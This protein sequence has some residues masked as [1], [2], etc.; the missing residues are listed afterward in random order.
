MFRGLGRRNPEGGSSY[1]VG[2]DNFVTDPFDG[3][4]GEWDVLRVFRGKYSLHIGKDIYMVRGDGRPI[5]RLLSPIS[6]RRY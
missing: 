3:I 5:T 4:E 2:G 1:A 6:P